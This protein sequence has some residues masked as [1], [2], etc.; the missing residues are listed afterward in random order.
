MVAEQITKTIKGVMPADLCHEIILG[1]CGKFSWLKIMINPVSRILY[2]NGKPF[3]DLR[4]F[5]ENDDFV[6]KISAMITGVLDRDAKH[7]RRVRH[8]KR[9]KNRR[10]K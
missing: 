10:I 1:L 7:Q 4:Q 5:H 8:N 6:G 9:K 3:A 2:I